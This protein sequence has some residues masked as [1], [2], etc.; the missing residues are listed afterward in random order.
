MLTKLDRFLVLLDRWDHPDGHAL[1]VRLR[2]AGGKSGQARVL[3]SAL[4]MRSPWIRANAATILG[5]IGERTSVDALVGALSDLDGDIRVAAAKSL[6]MIGDRRATPGLIRALQDEQWEVREEAVNALAALRDPEAVPALCWAAV[7]TDVSPPVRLAVARCLGCFGCDDT[8]KALFQLA[9]DE[10]SKV[11]LAVLEQ[12]HRFDSDRG[13]ELIAL[14]LK[15]S[16]ARVRHQAICA[17]SRLQGVGMPSLLLELLD[18]PDP[19][20]QLS[21]AAEFARRAN[22]SHLPLL[23]ELMARRSPE[24]RP[25]LLP[26]LGRIGGRE[27]ILALVEALGSFQQDV[28]V[29][30]SQ[31]LMMC[32]MD[33]SD[34]ALRVALPLLYRLE[35]KARGLF[36][37][38]SVWAANCYRETAEMIEYVTRGKGSLPVTV[39][40]AAKGAESLPVPSSGVPIAGS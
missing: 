18:D 15:D 17:I 19:S 31:A 14:S 30:A 33:H 10:Q 1:A 21:A 40:T 7:V 34:P 12:A 16:D 37:D 8:F 25:T 39:I 36:G 23:L 11:R 5:L 2:H 22:D 4:Q 29:C 35:R 3:E 28:R 26:A 38:R 32:A 20:I 27:A 9:R 13:L 24:M 6:A